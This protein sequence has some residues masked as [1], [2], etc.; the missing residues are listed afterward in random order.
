MAFYITPNSNFPRG[1]SLHPSDPITPGLGSPHTAMDSL[2]GQPHSS[3]SQCHNRS[4]LQGG[5][6]QCTGTS[7]KGSGQP[8]NLIR[9]WWESRRHSKSH[10]STGFWRNSED[11]LNLLQVCPNDVFRMLDFIS[12]TAVLGCRLL[13]MGGSLFSVGLRKGQLRFTVILPGFDLSC[14]DGKIAWKCVSSL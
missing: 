11:A 4:P 12:R 2:M 5:P 3:R 1:S 10:Q 8:E 14:G 7:S 6:W 13:N 9:D